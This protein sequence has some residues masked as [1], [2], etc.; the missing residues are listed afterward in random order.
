MENT[1]TWAPDTPR[2]R[3][4]R[5]PPKPK[6]LTRN[7]LDNRTTAAKAFDRLYAE[8]SRPT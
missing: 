2:K 5:N 4:R 7:D 6:I 8:I 1:Q 3:R